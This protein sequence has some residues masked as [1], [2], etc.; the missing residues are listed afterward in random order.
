MLD[1]RW[2]DAFVGQGKS[3][4]P[5][6]TIELENRPDRSAH[7]LA[8][9]VSRV[10]GNAQRTAPDKS[11]DDCVVSTGPA[12][13]LLP[14]HETDPIAG[15]VGVYPNFEKMRPRLILSTLNSQLTTLNFFA[16]HFVLTNR[17]PAAPAMYSNGWPAITLFEREVD[18]A[19]MGVFQKPRAIGLLPRSE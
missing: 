11:R 3:N 16:C 12:R 6:A 13:W 1:D 4:G 14:R 8:L 17:E 10:T 19:G 9:H 15:V 7:L 2:S 5:I 18:C